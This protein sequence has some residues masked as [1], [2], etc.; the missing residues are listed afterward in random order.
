MQRFVHLGDMA[1]S[2]GSFGLSTSQEK[3]VTIFTLL[4][5]SCKRL[6]FLAPSNVE[7]VLKGKN[8]SF[9]WLKVNLLDKYRHQLYTHTQLGLLDK[10]NTL[11][12][13]SCFARENVAVSDAQ[14]SVLRCTTLYCEHVVVQSGDR[15][16]SVS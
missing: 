4:S 12:W 13:S 7:T 10:F 6:V 15:Q 5:T 2:W 11:F 14:H 3:C 8:T 16:R 1:C 9:K